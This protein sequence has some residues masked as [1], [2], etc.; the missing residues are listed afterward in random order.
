MCLKLSR[1]D[2]LRDK[3]LGQIDRHYAAKI[4]AVLGPMASLH[5][6]KRIVPSGAFVADKDAILKRAAEQDE[7]LAA[8]DKERRELK[9][10][11]RAAATAAEI[12]ALIERI[13]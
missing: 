11:V 4:D 6:L 1:A 7:I 10:A 12:K 9:A 5:L 8:I 3:A 13:H 2:H